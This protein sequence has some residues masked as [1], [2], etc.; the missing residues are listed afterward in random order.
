MS[1]P[2]EE[3][4]NNAKRAKGDLPV[5]EDEPDATVEEEVKE[6]TQGV[7]EVELEAENPTAI[8]LPATPPPEAEMA[9]QK[10]E[11]AKVEKKTETDGADTEAVPAPLAEAAAITSSPAKATRSSTSDAPAPPAAAI[12]GSPTSPRKSGRKTRKL[13]ARASK[14]ASK[15]AKKVVAEVVEPEETVTASSDA[16]TVVTEATESKKDEGKDA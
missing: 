16:G 9:E 5:V 15:G 13:P 3:D 7:K 12:T 11:S 10:V 14:P 2:G 1:T 8:P 4:E 6:V